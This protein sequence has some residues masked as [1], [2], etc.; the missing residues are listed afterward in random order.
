MRK[1]G[2]SSESSAV[3]AL[4]GTFRA[5][6]LTSTAALVA[7]VAAVGA[8]GA[9]AET[10]QTWTWYFHMERAT[11]TATPAVVALTLVSLG[12]LLGFVLVADLE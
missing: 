5:I 11:A 7:L 9:Y 12:S 6:A 2:T 8:V 1:S 3:R 10:Q 4:E